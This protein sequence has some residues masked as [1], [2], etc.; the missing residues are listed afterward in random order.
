M[1]AADLMRKMVNDYLP[2]KED[3]MEECRSTFENASADGLQEYDDLS[4]RR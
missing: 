1:I 2:E 4:L 3:L